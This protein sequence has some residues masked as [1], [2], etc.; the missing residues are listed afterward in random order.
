MSSFR[1][2]RSERVEDMRGRID[3]RL[4][5]RPWGLAGLKNRKLVLQTA[6]IL[7][8]FVLNR[9]VEPFCATGF[10]SSLA[11]PRPAIILTDH[12]S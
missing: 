5:F 4:D 11:R 1:I 9:H 12:E 8:L 6:L 2:F 3:R 10:K 7:H